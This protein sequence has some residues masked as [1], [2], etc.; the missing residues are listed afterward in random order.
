[1]STDPLKFLYEEI[2]E[3]DIGIKLDRFQHRFLQRLDQ[4]DKSIN[5]KTV[6]KEEFE[7]VQ[8]DIKGFNQRMGSFIR[9]EPISKEEYRVL[10][11]TMRTEVGAL[12][13]TILAVK[14][15]VEYL[16]EEQYRKDELPPNKFLN[17]FSFK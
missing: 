16:A 4:I 11:E 17:C 9:R 7:V 12:R 2:G 6:R 1:M 3:L 5:T 8:R 15:G 10:N 13:G 14:D